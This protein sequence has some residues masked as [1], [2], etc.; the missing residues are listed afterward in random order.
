MSEIAIK[1]IESFLLTSQIVTKDQWADALKSSKETGER[2]EKILLKKGYISLQESFEILEL[3]Y[4]APFINLTSEIVELEALMLVPEEVARSNK[5]LPICVVT[6][7]L[8]VAMAN[9]QDLVAIDH[10]RFLTSLTLRVFFCFEEDIESAIDFYYNKMKILPTPDVFSESGL[11]KKK[12]AAPQVTSVEKVIGAGAPRNLKKVEEQPALEMVNDIFRMAMQ[13]SATDIHFEPD[14][15]GF[16]LLRF[17][18][19]GRLYDIQ[20]IPPVIAESIPLRIKVLANIST[21]EIS[22]SFMNDC[23][24]KL[25]DRVLSMRISI[26]RTSDGER[27]NCRILNQK[28][29]FTNFWNLI[30]DDATFKPIQNMVNRDKGLVLFCSP[31]GNKRDT[32]ATL[33]A[34]LNMILSRDASK[35]IVVIG[36]SINF[37]FKGI[38]YLPVTRNLSYADALNSVLNQDPDIVLIDRIENLE[39]MEMVFRLALSGHMVLSSLETYFHS[40]EVISWLV[41]NGISPYWVACGLTGIITQRWAKRNCSHCKTE[42]YLVDDD[43]QWDF[44]DIHDE[45]SKYM[46][47]HA[48]KGCAYCHNTGYYSSIG[49]YEIIRL[50]ERLKFAVVKNSSPEY[51]NE[52]AKKE[53]M[54]MLKDNAM[55]Y[56]WSGQIKLDDVFEIVI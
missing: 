29:T 14:S 18:I 31:P 15:Q 46:K 26:I 47:L 5:L 3:V 9:P 16:L 10:L 27:I 42:Y 41:Q 23:D 45:A 55:K 36:H 17:R 12:L 44:L 37:M 20:K 33:F 4:D 51:I 6:N 11:L 34:I 7:Q 32:D 19:H 54:E 28:H 21:T 13:T 52:V 38:N 48:S 35:S 30:M 50:T 22:Y 43:W 24:V 2:I 8:I 49:I 1:K 56:V 53:G 40:A 25:D 39:I